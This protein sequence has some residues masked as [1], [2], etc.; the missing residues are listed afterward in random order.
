[1]RS[2]SKIMILCTFI[3]SFSVFAASYTLD[4]AG[5]KVTLEVNEQEVKAKIGDVVRT[6]S[7]E[8]E[9]LAV[10]LD[11]FSSDLP[12]LQKELDRL[13]GKVDEAPAF[14]EIDEVVN[15][16]FL[17]RQRFKVKV[18][19]DKFKVFAQKAYNE[20]SRIIQRKKAEL[21]KALKDLSKELEGSFS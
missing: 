17:G 5:Q 19:S 12:H 16:P 8:A 18:A 4:V 14:I 13:K 10:K 11:K 7:S 2:F 9:R 3:S 1:M 15:I 21:K 6:I 20:A